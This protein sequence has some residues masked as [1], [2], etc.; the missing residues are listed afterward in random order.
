MTQ[1]LLEGVQEPEYVD[2]VGEDLARLEERVTALESLA[3]SA[4]RRAVIAIL[5]VLG[6]AMR[7]V[8]SGK[9][10]LS[11]P[12]VAAPQ[13]HATAGLEL[14]KSKLG[15]QAARIIDALVHGPKTRAQLI[16]VTGIGDKNISQVIYKV[17]KANLIAKVGDTYSLKGL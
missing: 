11:A 7:E 14:W 3:A 4:D 10:E 1:P 8:A 15:G 12:A 6:A 5:N 16:I 9:Y 13:A 2:P 17:N